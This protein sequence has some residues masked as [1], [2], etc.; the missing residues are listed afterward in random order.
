MIYTKKIKDAI[1]FSIKTHEVYQKQKRKGKDIPYITHPLTVGLILA[2]AGASE[3]VIIAGILH[4]T[5]EDSTPEKKVTREMIAER[6]GDKVGELVL[7]VTETNK[8]LP[9][10]ERKTEALEHIKKFSQESVLIKS[11]DVISNMSELLNDHEQEGESVWDRFNAPK[12]KLLQ[13]THRVISTLINQWP[14]SLLA[15]DL[16][17]INDYLVEIESPNQYP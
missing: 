1:K 5:V 15:S 3:E 9:W 4:D 17:A 6:F 10:E 8:E 2:R 11:A 13:N 16:Q 12:D 7:S 14:E